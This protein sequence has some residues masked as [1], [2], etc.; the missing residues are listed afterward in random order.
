MA[1]MSQYRSLVAAP[2]SA[3]QAL[4]SGSWELPFIHVLLTDRRYASERR[5]RVAGGP[6][7]SGLE[8]AMTDIR[9]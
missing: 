6:S 4:V 1:W 3:V 8:I 9:A 2:L 7:A 5:L